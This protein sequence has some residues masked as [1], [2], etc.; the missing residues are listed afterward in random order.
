MTAEVDPNQ[1]IGRLDLISMRTSRV[2]VGLIFVAAA[3]VA[4][5]IV[6]G[7]DPTRSAAI[8]RLPSNDEASSTGVVSESHVTNELVKK[9][10]ESQLIG[11]EPQSTDLEQAEVKDD[12]ALLDCIDAAAELE[13]LR[14]DAE[15]EIPDSYTLLFNHLELPESQ[16]HKLTS[17]LV[18]FRVARTYTSCKQGIEIDPQNRSDMIE[19]IIGPTKVAR[20]LSLEQNMYEYSEIKF[21]DC[22]LNN[23]GSS[24][25][26]AQRDRLFEIIVEIA[27]RKEKLPG[28]GA[29]RHSIEYL[30]YQLAELNER[31]RL[32]LEQVASELSAEQVGYLFDEYQR[33]S[34]QQADALERQKRARLDPKRNPLPTYFP[35]RR[36]IARK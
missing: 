32:F 26:G 25:T 4:L 29:E 14:A 27:A 35:A 17:L 15:Q 28:S 31:T 13:E 36:C 7:D 34:Y 9:V 8:N 2:I 33:I 23:N 24:L 6:V 20:F 21:V 22:V 12:T 3:V 19:A 18:E 10:D 11:P 30:E 5:I 1:P 16:K